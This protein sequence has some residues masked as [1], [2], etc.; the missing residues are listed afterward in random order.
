M[1]NLTGDSL[2]NAFFCKVF[3]EI[4]ASFV[5]HQRGCWTFHPLPKFHPLQTIII[6]YYYYNYNCEQILGNPNSK[7]NNLIKKYMIKC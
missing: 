4:T 7:C 3:G 6:I 5:N 2:Q 1:H